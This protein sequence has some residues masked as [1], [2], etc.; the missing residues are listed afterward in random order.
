MFLL[1]LPDTP[2]STPQGLAHLLIVGIAVIL[3]AVIVGIL[4]LAGKVIPDVLSFVI[5]GGMFYLVGVNVAAR[6]QN[7]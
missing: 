6:A 4:A 1:T 5:T 2:P 3:C 7:K